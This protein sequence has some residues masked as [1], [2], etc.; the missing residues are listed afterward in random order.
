[1]LEATQQPAAG[2]PL[3]RPPVR[4]TGYIAHAIPK[5]VETPAQQPVSKPE[6]HQAQTSSQSRPGTVSFADIQRR[7][8]EKNATQRPIYPFPFQR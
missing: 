4:T 1:M 3:M 2:V 5:A 7:V 6:F 8:A